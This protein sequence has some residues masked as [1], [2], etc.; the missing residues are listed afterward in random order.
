[1]FV[2]IQWMDRSLMYAFHT[3]E[4]WDLIRKTNQI[5]ACIYATFEWI[6]AWDSWNGHLNCFLH[7]VTFQSWISK[8]HSTA[9]RFPGKGQGKE[10]ESN[11]DSAILQ[12]GRR[13]KQLI[14]PQIA[15][16]VWSHVGQYLIIYCGKS[17]N[18][19]CI[20]WS[21]HAQDPRTL[22]YKCK[23]KREKK[24]KTKKEKNSRGG[25]GLN[26]GQ[27][28]KASVF[29]TGPQWWCMTTW[30]SW[31]QLCYSYQES[32]SFEMNNIIKTKSKQ[33]QVQVF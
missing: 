8:M 1:M 6:F 14:C 33:F 4:I 29:T 25:G 19:I 22:K 9:A 12:V 18:N 23:I 11:L 5:A 15:V 3:N 13:L 28:S 16:I 20:L 30:M 7:T 32:I 21:G 27:D 24:R 2:T 10:K 17:A 31:K 26:S